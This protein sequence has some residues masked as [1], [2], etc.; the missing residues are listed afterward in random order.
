M[1]G[2]TENAPRVSFKWLP[3]DVTEELRAWPVGRPVDGTEIAILAPDGLPVEPGTIGEI[4]VRGSSLMT[5]YVGFPEAMAERMV[6]EWFL[7]RDLGWIDSAG[8]LHLVGR[9]DNVI[10]V[11]HEKVSPEEVEALLLTVPGVEDVAVAAVRDDRLFQ[12]PVA[13]LVVNEPLDAVVQAARRQLR[14]QLAIAKMPRHFLPVK[15]IPRTAYGKIDRS[16]VRALIA[17]LAL[18]LAA[19]G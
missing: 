12:V 1:Y 7:T 8:D 9:A 2:C 19:E 6:G 14:A 18:T 16:G 5:G 13:L 11:G 15:Y 10:L 3:P 4:G 17:E